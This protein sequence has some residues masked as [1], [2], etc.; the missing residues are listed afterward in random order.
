MVTDIN[1]ERLPRYPS[2][3]IVHSALFVVRQMKERIEALEALLLEHLE[4][5]QPEKD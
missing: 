3:G 2:S 1:A 4:D 5:L